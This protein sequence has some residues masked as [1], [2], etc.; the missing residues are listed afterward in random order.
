MMKKEMIEGIKILGGVLS[1]NAP[2][3]LAGVGIIG[4]IATTVSAVRA[5]PKALDA[6][7]NEEVKKKCPLG[8][9]EKVQVVWKDYI[10]TVCIGVLTIASI[11]GAYKVQAKRYATLVG[12]Y[13]ILDKSIDKYRALND[14]EKKRVNVG[15]QK[16]D[17]ISLSTPKLY[18]TLSGR[19]FDGT[20]EKV[21]AGINRANQLLLTENTVSLNEVYEL[22]GLESNDL[23]ELLGWSPLDGQVDI[24][25]LEIVGHVTKDKI[26]HVGID[27]EPRPKTVC[28]Y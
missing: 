3:I 26:P 5:T 7:E 23:G 25:E 28:I 12:A 21:E 6:I 11:A 4:V 17:N 24:I 20:V 8:T 15:S 2:K 1:K 27:F 19:Y 13:S 9:L 10:P 18:D 16:S 14:G 22:I